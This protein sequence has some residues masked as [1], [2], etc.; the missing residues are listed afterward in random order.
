M[1]TIQLRE[2][3][4]DLARVFPVMVQL[5]PHLSLEAFLAQARRQR[6]AHGW[7]LATVESG[8]RVLACAGY[9]IA[10]WLAWG[11]TLYVDDLVTTSTR[12]ARGTAIGSST[13][14]WR[15][16]A[17][18]AARSCTSTRASSGSR[19]IASTSGSGWTS[20]AIT[21]R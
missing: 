20:R 13:G 15:A 9:R 19:R 18:K 5:R 11:K 1:T 14:S 21:S 7:K 2:S 10:E 3:D 4:E 8:G 6:E 16:R 17:R 12:G